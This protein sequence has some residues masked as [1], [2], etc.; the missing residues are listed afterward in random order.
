MNAPS[1]LSLAPP[2]IVAFKSYA[3]IIDARSPHEYAE[4]HVPGAVNLPV[5]DD[6]EFAEV[7][8]LHLRNPHAAYLLGA[9]Y[10][11]RNI[12]RHLRSHVAAC[13][14]N[15][16]L[17]VYCFRGGKRSRAWADVL[18][19]IG[20]ATDV[21][22]GGWKAYRQWVRESLQMLPPRFEY[23][24]LSGLTGCGKTRLLQ[25]LERQG[26]QVVDLEGLAAHRGSLIGAV[27]D[28][29]QP[30]QKLFDSLLLD[31]LR[32]CDPARPVWV[33]AESKK[34]GNVQMP[35]ALFQAMRRTPRIEIC[36]SIA[37]RV[38]SLRQDYPNFVAD[39]ESMAQ[40]L[41][42]LRPLVGG[43]EVALWHALA[44]ERRVDELFERVLVAHYDPSYERSRQRAA[45]D[46]E[47]KFRVELTPTDEEQ[48]ASAAA[49]L[50]RRFG[51]VGA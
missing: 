11:L 49:E 44:H 50:A 48:L 23:R 13:D 15:A 29:P 47:T 37:D 16:R 36:A 20:Y 51:A 30:T 2:G 38:R 33:E 46:G 14:R 10:S 25:T 24:V 12:A 17:L 35:D 31:K 26:Q 34:I 27:P 41:D 43:E 39:P 4:D 8:I 40:K 19:N 1:E 42:P 28:R 18:R 45:L 21:L 7:G 3:L 32:A 6:A 22:P 5:V 9:E